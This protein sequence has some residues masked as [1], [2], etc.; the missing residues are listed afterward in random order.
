MPTK[1]AQKFYQLTVAKLHKIYHNVQKW[2]KK[3]DNFIYQV[4]Q[5]NTK[6]NP[7]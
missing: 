1:N 3:F 5:L 2:E 6:I 4:A 7:L